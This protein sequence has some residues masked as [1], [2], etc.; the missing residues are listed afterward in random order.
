MFKA[1]EH[2]SHLN[3]TCWHMKGENSTNI[4]DVVWLQ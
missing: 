3:Q 2:F 1:T 4:M